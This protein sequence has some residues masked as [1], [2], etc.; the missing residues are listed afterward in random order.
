[1]EEARFPWRTAL[2]VSLAINLLLVGLAVGAFAAGARLERTPAAQAL[3]PFSPRGFYFALPGDVRAAM[4]DDLIAAWRQS[5]DERR[6]VREAR[7]ALAEA[8]RDPAAG[9]EDVRAAF[10]RMRAA[11]TALQTQFHDAVA[12]ALADLTPQQRA[13]AVDALTK[14]RLRRGERAGGPFDE[15]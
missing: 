2:F 1:M 11:D 10:A 3:Q 7:I 14:A 4:R 15:K 13:E 5:D 6:A 9:A 8:A 12:A